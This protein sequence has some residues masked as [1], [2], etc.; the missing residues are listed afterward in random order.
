MKTTRGQILQWVRAHGPQHSRQGSNQFE[1]NLLEAGL[2][3]LRIE[4]ATGRENYLTFKKIYFSTESQELRK[5]AKAGREAVNL[6]K[7]LFN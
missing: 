2:Y 4:T 7:R 6:L 3:T 5:Y 1:Y